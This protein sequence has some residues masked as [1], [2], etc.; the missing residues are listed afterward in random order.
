MFTRQQIF[1]PP[2]L[3]LKSHALS[4]LQHSIVQTRHKASPD[5]QGRKR[6]SSSPWKDCQ[7]VVTIFNLSHLVF[8][9]YLPCFFGFAGLMPL[10]LCGN[11]ER[12]KDYAITTVLSEAS[13]E[14]FLNQ[15]TTCGTSLM[16]TRK[17]LAG[18]EVIM[19]STATCSALDS[20]RVA[21]F[22]NSLLPLPGSFHGNLSPSALKS[23]RPSACPG[24]FSRAHCAVTILCS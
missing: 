13:S 17:Y 5:P 15:L 4:L 3:R 9:K 24:G 23:R 10:F 19:S 11:S 12:C 6:D 1:S 16:Q 22:N 7:E 8:C 21:D 18:E 20:S 14:S 2:R